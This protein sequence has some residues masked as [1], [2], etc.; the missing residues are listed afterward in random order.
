MSADDDYLSK[1]NESNWEERLCAMETWNWTWQKEEKLR[2]GKLIRTSKLMQH[3][4]GD[5]SIKL[6]EEYHDE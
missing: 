6:R 3:F 1:F 4:R 2:A 5:L